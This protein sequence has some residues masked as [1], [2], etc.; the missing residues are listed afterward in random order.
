MRPLPKTISLPGP[1]A[2]P[3]GIAAAA[4]GLTF[5][6]SSR[7]D[8]TIFRGRIDESA[9]SVWLP[10]GTDGRTAACGMTIDARGR[11]LVCGWEGGQVFAYQT[12]TGELA[13]RHMVPADSALL[14]DVC[15][16]AD[17]AYVTD[18][19]RPVIWRLPV[20]DA[21][22]EPAEWLD[23]TAF[24]AAPEAS[25]LNG[26][27][28]DPSGTALLV[29][30]QQAEVLWRVDIASRTAEPVD[31][32]TDR[33]AADGLE[34]VGDMLYAC[35]ITEDADSSVSFWLTAVRLDREARAGKLA[36]RWPR[37]I[38]DT[39]TTLAHIAGRLYLVNSQI[40]A[41][42]QGTPPGPFT[43]SAVDLPA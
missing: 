43:I 33:L 38:E 14:N 41:E 18:S 17:F 28:A 27:I 22:G 23:L 13:A 1:A 37:R 36:G 35:D 7:R 2:F 9:A 30:A 4:D 31:L 21:V 6:V 40:H 15:V 8:G 10:P 11:L 20:A 34:L 3:E 32:G 39:P 42:R 25:F 12:A 29:S 19:S 26:I 16:C 24:G 5:Y